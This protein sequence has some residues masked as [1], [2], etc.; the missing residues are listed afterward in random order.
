M[1]AAKRALSEATSIPAE[2]IVESPAVHTT[3]NV[4]LGHLP[5]EDLQKAQEVIREVRYLLF[6]AH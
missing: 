1:E 3:V 4:R 2:Q 6:F 5:A